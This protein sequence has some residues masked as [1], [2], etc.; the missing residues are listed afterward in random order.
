[1]IM[2]KSVLTTMILSLAFALSL[3]AQDNYKPSSGIGFEVG[4]APFSASPIALDQI[5]VR[6]YLDGTLVPRVGLNIV[7]S[8]ESEPLS[9]TDDDGNEVK[10][11]ETKTSS[12]MFGL[13]PGVEYHFSGT[14]RISPYVGAEIGFATRSTKQTTEYASGSTE[15]GGEV[16]NSGEAYT[17]FGLNVLAGCQFFFLENAYLGTEF[18]FGFANKSYKD[19]ENKPSVGNSTTTERGSSMDLGVN[20]NAL[21]KLGY[22]F[23]L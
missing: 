15:T 23:E 18:G 6:Y 3:N 10:G 12:F 22:V 4:A 2:K 13:T 7:S 17:L 9:G 11:G 21:F 16:V 19:I 8:S 20:Y 1:M 14:D 5:M